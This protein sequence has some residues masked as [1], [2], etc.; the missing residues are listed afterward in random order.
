MNH[1]QVADNPQYQ[2]Q[3]RLEAMLQ[4]EAECMVEVWQAMRLCL[5]EASFD[6]ELNLIP[7][8]EQATFSLLTDPVDKSDILEGI[9]HDQ[10][11]N[12]QGEIQ[13]RADGRIYAEVDVICNHPSDVRWFVESVTAWGKN[14]KLTTELRLLPAV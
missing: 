2:K 9:W 8:P 1:E 3:A 4:R 12:K 7:R 13:I 6:A 5:N 10:R 14:A 11:G